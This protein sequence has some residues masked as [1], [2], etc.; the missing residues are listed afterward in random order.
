[1]TNTDPADCPD[2]A[3]PPHLSGT[4]CEATVSHGPNRWHRCL[5]LA[6][7]GAALP[8]PP[9]MTCQGGTLGYADIWYLQRGH[10]LAGA[11]GEI[12]PEMLRVEPRRPQ[13]PAPAT[14]HGPHSPSGTPTPAET[15]DRAGDGRTD[16]RVIRIQYS[17]PTPP[18]CFCGASTFLGRP[19]H[20]AGC[21]WRLDP[22][23]LRKIAADALNRYAEAQPDTGPDSR[24]D[25]PDTE[26]DSTADTQT[27][28]PTTSADTD[29]TTPDNGLREQYAAAIHAELL[30]T[31]PDDVAT[32]LTVTDAVMRVRDRHM[33]Q[34]TNRLIYAA[35][36]AA[37]ERG[38]AY[39]AEQRAEE[40][41][42]AITR[43][44]RLV[45]HW[46]ST[47]RPG[48]YHPA[49]RAVFAALDGAPVEPHPA[50][51]ERDGA[52]RE[53][54]HL[55]AW[56]SAL[57]P[58]NAVITTAADIDEPG[59]QLLFL[60]VG[61]WQMSWRI[62]PRDAGLFA[63]VEHVHP[64]DP[65]AQRDGHSTEAKYQRIQEHVFGL[66]EARASASTV[67]I[68][69]GPDPAHVVDAIRQ[70]RRDGGLPPHRR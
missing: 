40:A 33:E 48:E 51:A 25:S 13:Q 8:C 70:V 43:V 12:S 21:L 65:R 2:C 11:D 9:Q 10:T 58:A 27:D 56:I 36:V 44:R 6:R 35:H 54:A 37:D 28:N 64:T 5:C 38:R 31:H 23:P 19:I 30:W 52:Y 68:E 22:E 55:L 60:L 17:E 32:S 50:E 61:G 14:P 3:H 18:R 57:H 63:H 4:E 39:N 16:V 46:Q 15:P 41:E 53:R 7:P 42:A 34:I 47:V 24:T 29:R 66:G 45:E 20:N 1:M 67:R 62:H 49:T 59:W 26:P 69:I